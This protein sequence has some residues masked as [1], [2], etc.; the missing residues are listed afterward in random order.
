MSPKQCYKNVSSFSLQTVFPNRIKVAQVL[1]IFKRDEKMFFLITNQDRCF[2]HSPNYWRG[3][4]ATDF[5]STFHKLFF[6]MIKKIGFQSSKLTELEVIV[7]IRKML[8][9]FNK[10]KYKQVIFIDLIKAFGIIDHDK[11]LK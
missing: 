8:D 1:P 2:H 9:D 7:L 10:N 3:W 6:L 11:L 5:T 4:C